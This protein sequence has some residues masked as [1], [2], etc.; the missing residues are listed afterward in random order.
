M[1][2]SE[3]A[4]TT[5]REFRGRRYRLAYSIARGDGSRIAAGTIVEIRRKFG[6]LTVRTDTCEHCGVSLG[7][8][9][10]DYAALGERV[11]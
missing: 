9:R 6:G 5:E 11:S 7:I 10:V 4:K 2:R 3:Y 1:T 8:A